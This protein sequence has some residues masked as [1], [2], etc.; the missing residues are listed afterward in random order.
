MPS[1]TSV[2]HL[3]AV[4]LRIAVPAEPPASGTTTPGDGQ[5]TVFAVIVFTIISR[6]VQSEAVG[7]VSVIV[8]LPLQI[9]QLVVSATVWFPVMVT[10]AFRESE[11]FT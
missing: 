9:I 7:K 3:P 6:P 1:L 11:P 2:A 5:T 8:P 10:G 4:A